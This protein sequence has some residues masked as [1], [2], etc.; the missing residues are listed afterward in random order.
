[1][2]VDSKACILDV[3]ASGTCTSDERV[4]QRCTIASAYKTSYVC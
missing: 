4:K 2:T 1:M 3:S